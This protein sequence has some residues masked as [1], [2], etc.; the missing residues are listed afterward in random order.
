[1]DEE[2][3]RKVLA[4]YVET[5]NKHDI[6]AWGQLFTDDVDYINRAGGWWKSNHENVRGHVAI[7]E[8]LVQQRKKMNYA[9]TVSKISFLEPD[10][11]LVHAAWKWPG[12][13]T[14]TGSATDDINGIATLLMVKRNSRWLIRALQNTVVESSSIAA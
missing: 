5:W 12:F 9:A 1:M 6:Q 13:R 7:H 8:V 2:A 10:I 4:T 3:I 11:A 14:P